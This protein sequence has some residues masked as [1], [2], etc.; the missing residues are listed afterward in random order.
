MTNDQWPTLTNACTIA[1]FSAADDGASF[2]FKQKNKQ[3]GKTAN[4]GR[5]NVEVIMPL[6]NLSNFLENSRNVFN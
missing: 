2:N 4:G 3:T 6:K 1:N 5:K